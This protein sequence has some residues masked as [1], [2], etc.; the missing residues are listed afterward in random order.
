MYGLCFNPRAR[1]G[2]DDLLDGLHGSSYLFQSTRPRGA[3]RNQRLPAVS[4]LRCFNP[5]AR[6]GRDD[7]SHWAPT[8]R[9]GFNPRARVGRDTIKTWTF[10]LTN[11][12]QSTRPRGARPHEI[13]NHLRAQLFQSTRPRGAQR[14][15]IAGRRAGS[16]FNPRA[17]VGRDDVF[18]LSVIPMISFNPRARVGRDHGRHRFFCTGRV[19]IHAPAWGATYAFPCI[20]CLIVFQSTRP[21]GARPL[22]P[23][24][25]DTATPFQSTRPRGARHEA[26]KNVLVD[27]RVSIHA[28]A[29]GATGGRAV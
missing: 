27:E 14:S 10:D 7:G 15:R 17:R 21:R 3:R 5:R 19:S 11:K 13:R 20:P 18:P 26:G 8:H 23:C 6:V 4:G 28:P 9:A 24:G 22:P 12:F 1:V 16:C 2:R 29:W 25:T